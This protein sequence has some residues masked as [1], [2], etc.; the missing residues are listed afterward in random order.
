M[1]FGQNLQFL[2]KRENLTQDQLAE[3]FGVSRQTVSKWES[4]GC[5]PETE[6]LLKMCEMFNCDMDTL[7]R[8]D[9]CK[10]SSKSGYDAHM[11]RFTHMICGGVALVLFG[12]TFLVFLSTFDLLYSV[13][14]F[15]GIGTV[16]FLIFIAA[17]VMLFVVGGLRHSAFLQENPVKPAYSKPELDKFRR[18]FPWLIAVPIFLI[19]LGLILLVG[20]SLLIGEN[21]IWEILLTS[22][23][24]FFITVSVPIFVYAGMQNAKYG[25]PEFSDKPKS[26][27]TDDLIGSVCGCIMM[28]AVIVFL[29]LGFLGNLW[30]IA[31]VVF[32][33]GGVLCGI[34]T[35]LIKSIKKG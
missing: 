21:E 16:V 6:K 32:P 20:G 34:V 1:S 10:A 31:W 26:K 17:A 18:R 29:L 27:E 12:V 2:R 15:S 24:L 23:F 28:C 22:V 30:P 14:L 19:F 25:L 9:V 8:G 4:D 33:I 13:E 5:W 35:T 3:E 7:M 11:N